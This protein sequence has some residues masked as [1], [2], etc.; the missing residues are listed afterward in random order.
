MRSSPAWSLYGRYSNKIESAA[1][2]PG[3]YDPRQVQ[4]KSSI[5]FGS[6]TRDDLNKSLTSPGP[7]A[8]ANDKSSLTSSPV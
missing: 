1:P 7:G 4:G 2:G 3:N 6:S 8:Y 5:K